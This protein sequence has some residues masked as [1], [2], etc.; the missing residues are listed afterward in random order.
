MRLGAILKHGASAFIINTGM[1]HN[2]AC[3]NGT[4]GRHREKNIQA[5]TSCVSA[6]HLLPPEKY[7][8]GLRPRGHSYTLPYVQINYVNPLLFLDAYF[9]FFELTVFSITVFAV[10]LRCNICVCDLF[11]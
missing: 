2:N 11:Q 5:S 1:S 3:Q 4:L 6:S 10:L 8:L 9:V 7:H